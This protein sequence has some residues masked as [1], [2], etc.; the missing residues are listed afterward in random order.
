MG[1]KLNTEY[2]VATEVI[3]ASNYKE[4]MQGD[5]YTTRYSI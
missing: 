5:L 1:E 3:D 2:M 4:Y